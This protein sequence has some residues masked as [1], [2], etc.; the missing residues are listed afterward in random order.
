[1]GVSGMVMRAVG[2]AVSL[3]QGIL[4][5]EDKR[6]ANLERDSRKVRE[7]LNLDWRVAVVWQCV[8]EKSGTFYKT[9]NALEDWINSGNK[10]CEIPYGTETPRNQ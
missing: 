2:K 7:L 9:M 3:R 6:R 10:Y 8:L 1:M 5:G 4:S